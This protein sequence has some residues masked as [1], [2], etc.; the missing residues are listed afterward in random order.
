MRYVFG[1]Y[2]FDVGSRELRHAGHAIHLQP[3]VFQI[4]SYLILHRDRVVSADE[5]HEE[6]WRGRYVGDAALKSCIK[7]ARS[8]VGDNGCEQR[9]V[10]TLYGQG[11]R[12]VAPVRACADFA[13]PAVEP[14]P[15]EAPAAEPSRGEPEGATQA[16]EVGPRPSGIGVGDPGLEEHKLV[17]ALACGLR[18]GRDL[19]EQIGP[20]PIHR[21]MK[22]VL[23][24]A[25]E[26]VQRFDG[27]IVQW[28]GDGFVALFGA[29]TA[30]ED[31][32]R[33]AL[34]AALELA[35]ALRKESWAELPGDWRAPPLSFGVHS[36]SIL[37]GHLNGESQ[38]LFTAIGS[39]TE[40]ATK[41]MRR[42][43][44]ATPLLS[45]ATYRLVSDEVL[46]R[47]QGRV[48]RGPKQ[49]AFA[50]YALEEVS[51][52]RSGVPFG[53]NRLQTPF[54][55]RK[56]EIDLLKDRLHRAE[57][58]EGQIVTVTGEP[59]I[60]KTRL[61]QEFRRELGESEVPYWE[62][63]C[64][65]YGRT[66]SYLP[67]VDL[68]CERCGVGP[69]DP[70][71]RIAAALR[72]AIDA[73]DAWADQ[74]VS[75]VLTLMNKPADD[76]ILE[77]LSP[78]A[79]RQRRARAL[80]D[81]LFGEGTS[82]PR[83][84][85]IEDTHW[86]DAASQ[87]WLAEAVSYVPSRP[88]LLVLT[89]RPG[90]HGGALEQA[91]A[92]QLSIPRLTTSESG[93]LIRSVVADRRLGERLTSAMIARGGGNPFFLQEL[94][95]SAQKGVVSADA[96]K[97]PET[98]QAV[99][100]H[101]IDRLDADDKALLQL[102]AVIGQ[103]APLGLLKAITETADER[104]DAML[105]RLRASELLYTRRLGDAAV[106]SF[107]HALTQEVAYRSLLKS[108]RQELHARIARVLEARF[109][110]WSE[111][112]P[113]LLAHH[114]TEA[115]LAELA[116]RY[117]YAAG[118]RA[119]ER[120]AN[121]EV[122]AHLKK[123]LDLL[124]TLPNSPKRA[125]QE[126]DLQL[127]LCSA[128]IQTN[129][130][131]AAELD[132]HYLRARRLCEEVGEASQLFTVTH[133]LW[134]LYA[135][136]NEL[137]AADELSEE[138]LVLARQQQDPGLCLQAHHAAWT[139]VFHLGR[140]GACLAH[141][142]QAQILY[143]RESHASHRFLYAGHDP[144][145][146]SRNFSA[147]SLALL[148]YPD[149]AV[150]CVRDAVALARSLDHPFSLVLALFASAWV[151]HLRR[152]YGPAR[153]F[154]DAVIALCGEQAIAPQHAIKARIIRDFTM[155]I[156]GDPERV[157]AEA[158]GGSREV[159]TCGGS[160]YLGLIA[161]THGRAGD[162]D[163]GLQVLAEAAAYIGTTDERVWEAEIHRLRGEL[164]VE[165]GA[166]HE[167]EAS[168]CF[169]RALEI[170]RRQDAKLLELRAAT[171][172]ARL[173]RDQGQDAEARDL[174]VRIYGWFSEGLDTPDLADAGALLDQLA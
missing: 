37:L 100:A 43:P 62:G 101:R 124:E 121:L 42:A 57:E 160:Y 171:S 44:S 111:A 140:P 148:G 40:I 115:G 143:D 158:Q 85:A 17:T 132:P 48:S 118:Q 55:G 95:W 105:G 41:L 169:A 166:V 3:R 46:V 5:L 89:H 9:V 22:Q 18:D 30:H 54:I 152:E 99:L 8:A 27:T 87:A 102:A 32:A 125:R 104:I 117:C 135:A 162:V 96:P 4:L 68:V 153:E 25:E 53:R 164:L 109:P 69:G 1:D 90:H 51:T 20:E 134:N 49:G 61:L 149:Q 75:L 76:G 159:L 106:L 88:V 139:N 123:G 94:A 24:L 172:L 26:V 133:G 45:D 146:C 161:E 103:D 86:I 173:R 35:A 127:A 116:V 64:L 91:S 7:A 67:L 144:G 110:A 165:T 47:P 78:E 34:L 150:A 50:V 107:R 15:Q 6:I 112:E 39:T 167:G 157:V 108:K 72:A 65:S 79:V 33:A 83:V 98:V 119:S 63:R 58:G 151:H 137:N 145:V 122:A 28:L 38:R 138:L 130:Q 142:E 31:H 66:T 80:R 29:P 174:L 23:G 129:G 14:P 114:F 2:E 16:C 84:I 120:S 156:D 21:V 97:I 128:L 93:D 154:A 81:L 59:G 163:A 170:A 52:R 56:S 92:T 10:R 12:F 19:A 70:V 13:G 126:L 131:G 73:E 155:A 60:G 168:A 71:D 74:A 147:L 77:K 11:Y 136:R 82:G 113:G 141:A 36:G